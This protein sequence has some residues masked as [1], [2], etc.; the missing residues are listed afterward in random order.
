MKPS[1]LVKIIDDKFNLDTDL[2]KGVFVGATSQSRIVYNSQ[3]DKSTSNSVYNIQT[4]GTK[5]VLDPNAYIHYSVESVFTV[6]PQVGI[7]PLA[8]G[9]T[10]SLR[11]YPVSGEISGMSLSYANSTVNLQQSGEI[12]YPLDRYFG[13]LSEKNKDLGGVPNYPDN[14]L[15]YSDLIAKVSN[16]LSSGNEIDRRHRGDFI[17]T[18]ISNVAGSSSAT[19]RFETYEPLFLLGG[20]LGNTTTA[21]GPGL[22]G[23]DKLTLL[24]SYRNDLYRFWSTSQTNIT[25]IV[26]TFFNAPQLILNWSQPPP[27]LALDITKRSLIVPHTTINMFTSSSTSIASGSSFQYSFQ[28]I[29]QSN[30]ANCIF[31][32]GQVVQQDKDWTSTD[33]FASIEKMD[34]VVGTKSSQFSQYSKFDLYNIA[35]ENGLK[36]MSYSDFAQNCGSVMKIL[37]G[38]NIAVSDSGLLTAGSKESVNIQITATFKN[39][40]LSTKNFTF[41]AVTFTEGYLEIGSNSQLQV[42]TGFSERDVYEA[43]YGNKDVFT[44]KGEGLTEAIGKIVRLGRNFYDSVNTGVELASEI[45][46]GKVIGGKTIGGK[47]LSREQ[48]MEINRK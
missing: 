8:L 16:P 30:V 4:P 22:T 39:N 31:V 46:G 48:L 34:I 2:V 9:S 29:Q 45:I 35:V 1:S 25:S 17:I 7:A 13:I 3:T 6:T 44:A 37:P 12:L 36:N 40:Y 42:S 47:S 32:F 15:E 14:S 21:S 33:S 10:I 19:V 43:S 5:A 18:V 28:N 27:S 41:Y 20:G 26:S 24:V 38:R 11:Q 23:L